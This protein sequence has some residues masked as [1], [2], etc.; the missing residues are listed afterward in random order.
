M[1]NADRRK[2]ITEYFTRTVTY[3]YIFPQTM[4]QLGEAGGFR[5]EAEMFENAEH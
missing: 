2:L 5:L 3:P 4:P 1:M